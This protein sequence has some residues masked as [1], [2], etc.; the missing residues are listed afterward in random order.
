[1][2]VGDADYPVAL[3]YAGQLD[4]LENWTNV[5]FPLIRTKNIHIERSQITLHV[6]KSYRWMDFRGASQLG[7]REEYASG[8]KTYF[9]EQV[10]RITK[11][12]EAGSSYERAR[13]Y[14]NLTQLE[15][16]L[17]S[18]DSIYRADAQRMVESAKQQVIEQE[19]TEQQ[20]PALDNR[21]QLNR[22]YM[23]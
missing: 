17:Q 1:T 7:S 18:K 6:P 16:E 22:F 3:V 12:S 4:P 5:H 10:Q 23:E 19:R 21:A 13:A 8:F 15:S 20:A 9:G 14:Q 2:E 11:L